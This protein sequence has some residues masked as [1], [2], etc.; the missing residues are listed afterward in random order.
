MASV[1]VRL[2]AKQLA[3]RDRRQAALGKQ[4]DAFAAANPHVATVRIPVIP[5]I[6]ASNPTDG[7][8]SRGQKKAPKPAAAK[9]KAKAKAA[10]PGRRSFV[11][12]AGYA[13]VG[14]AD[15]ELPDGSTLGTEYTQAECARG[16]LAQAKCMA[17]V[18]ADKHGDETGVCEL[19][20]SAGGA[21]AKEG[22]QCVSR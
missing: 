15:V 19:W 10:A 1:R 7:A 16:C 5:I 3:T 21:K 9:A 22:P 14:A 6:P 18:Y 20:S 2:T 11:C 4:A 12:V 17:Y 8:A 13:L